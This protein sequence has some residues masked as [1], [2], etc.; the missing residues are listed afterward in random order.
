VHY[1]NVTG[2]AKF[3]YKPTNSNTWRYLGQS[4][5]T[6]ANPG[7]V[8]I[9]PADT[10]EG[11]FKIIFPAQAELPRLKRHAVPQLTIFDGNRR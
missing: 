10:L 8:A 7:S 2:I 6:S 3:Y 9:E 5:A 1:A 11:T 4:R